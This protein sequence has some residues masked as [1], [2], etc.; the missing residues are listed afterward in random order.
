[1]SD[2]QGL[3]A[4][5]PGGLEIVL[6]GPDALRQSMILSRSEPMKP[7]IELTFRRADRP[8]EGVY[9]FKS[10]SWSL[11]FDLVTEE[12]LEKLAAIDGPA[13]AVLR[14]EEASY[15]ARNG[16]PRGETVTVLGPVLSISGPA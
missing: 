7:Q 1:M 10:S 12:T 2:L 15:K 5:V 4:E 13:R 9:T 6:D 3:L 14:L 8:E 11:A 16:E